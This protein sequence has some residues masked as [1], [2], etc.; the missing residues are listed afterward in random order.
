MEKPYI[1][2]SDR[3]FNVNDAY[4]FLKQH[5]T[6][7]ATAIFVG[8]VDNYNNTKEVS[9][10]N[11]EI[12]APLAQKILADIA[13]EV[14][15]LYP[16]ISAIYIAHAKSFVKIGDICTLVAACAS[17]WQIANAICLYIVEQ[18]KC[19]VPIWKWEHYTDGSSEWLPGSNSLKKRWHFYFI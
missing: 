5:A 16:N 13:K 3:P 14:Q 2:I 6:L 17:S 12:Y 15:N 1:E 4:A 18:M 9:G 19:R 8:N 7:R 11:Y 10:I